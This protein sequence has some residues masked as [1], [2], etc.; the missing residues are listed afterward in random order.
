[1]RP[2]SKSVSLRM[3]S[4]SGRWLKCDLEQRS[5]LVASVVVRKSVLAEWQLCGL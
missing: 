3:S 1:M 4:V 2:T 5:I